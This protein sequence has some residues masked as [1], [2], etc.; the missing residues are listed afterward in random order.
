M[1]DINVIGVM[2][3][4]QAVVAVM[5]K[6]GGGQIISTVSTAGRHVGARGAFYGATK[7]GLM[8]YSQGMRIELAAH[9]IKV[10]TVCP[11]ITNTDAIDPEELARR[12]KGEQAMLEP[13]EV[14]HVFR[15]IVEQSAGSD[16]RDILITPFG[17]TR[18]HF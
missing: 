11:G 5:K 10:A 6:Q 14:A 18:Y 1:F 8:G 2:M 17:S 12:P 15:T 9:N 13:R 3:L 7:H 16:I 4:T